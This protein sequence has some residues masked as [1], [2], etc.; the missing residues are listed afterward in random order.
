M[1]AADCAPQKNWS[2]TVQDTLEK[3]STTSSSG[4]L[5]PPPVGEPAS[6]RPTSSVSRPSGR[7]SHGFTP[8]RTGSACR[9]Q[10]C[11][12]RHYRRRHRVENSAPAP[13]PA[14]AVT[15][16]AVAAA[17]A[18]SAKAAPT[19]RQSTA[20]RHAAP[21]CITKVGSKGPYPCGGLPYM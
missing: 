9:W 20:E 11:H 5:P 14:A 7:R 21:E 19:L 17:Q 4:H 16:V 10:A 18:T 12:R 15:A 13:A 1:R 6:S 8:M 2:M 3:A